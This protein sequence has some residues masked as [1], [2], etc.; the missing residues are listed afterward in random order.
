MKRK[1]CMVAMCTTFLLA[2]CSNKSVDLLA[3]PADA[4]TE[5]TLAS[6]QN[7]ETNQTE[8]RTGGDYASA[9]YD[10]ITDSEELNH[11]ND[12]A[13]SD[14]IQM[15]SED[16]IT[17]QSD[18][19]VSESTEQSADT[20]L[21]VQNVTIQQ[22]DASDSSFNAEESSESVAPTKTPVSTEKPTAVP[23]KAPVSTAK[24]TAVPTKAPTAT[25]KPT[26]VPTQKPSDTTGQTGSQSS[27]VSIQVKGQTIS[28]GES[29]SSL[30]SKLGSPNRTDVTEFN[31][32]YYVYNSNYSKF[33]MIAV[34]NDKVVGWYTDSNDFS[35]CGLTTNSTVAN[36]NAAFKTSKSLA[37]TI[38]VTS[39][40]QKITFFMDTLGNGTIDGIYVASS[41]VTSTGTTDAVLTAWEKEVLDLTNSFRERNG[42][43]ALSWSDQ[44]AKSAKKHSQDMASN[45]YFSHTSLDGR[46]PYD[47]MTAEGISYRSAG[48]NII[49]GYGNALYSVNGWVNS[50][51]HRSNLLSTSFTKLGAGFALGGSYG[52]YCTQ[53]FFS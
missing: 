20:N 50:S 23:T 13:Q 1:L 29:K 36:I 33:A 14:E 51:G 25:A 7:T 45:G 12:T 27:E 9:S 38:T 47:R 35:Y 32:S 37:K 16:E 39:N 22:T 44:A 26:A 19:S 17:N 5:T 40:G 31:Y 4:E 24:P 3:N 46:T 43:S 18:E 15:Y 30:V 49:G 10:E 48:E 6:S 41:S 8:E 53:N 42:L 21:Q 28:M 34:A 11:E 2:G 52:N